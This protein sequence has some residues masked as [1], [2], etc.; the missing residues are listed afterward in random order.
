MPRDMIA[1]D[2]PEKIAF[3]QRKITADRYESIPRRC[4][5]KRLFSRLTS[6]QQTAYDLIEQGR[7]YELTG[8]PFAR[9]KYSDSP[10][11]ADYEL[12][13]RQMQTLLDYRAWRKDIHRLAP[14]CHYAAIGYMDGK[15]LGAIEHALRVDTGKA[16]RYI[17]LALNRYCLMKGWGDQERGL[18]LRKVKITGYAVELR[19]FQAD[20]FDSCGR[21]VADY[22]F[23]K[24]PDSG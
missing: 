7:G 8:L 17:S 2:A 21:P 12:T 1:D 10:T 20:Y 6:K 4:S 13:P 14:A 19:L 5:A 18:G 22:V 23:D 15:S 11:G 24:S 16:A 9:M 3:E